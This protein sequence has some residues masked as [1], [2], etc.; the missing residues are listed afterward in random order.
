[1]LKVQ[2]PLTLDGWD[3]EFAAI[4]DTLEQIEIDDGIYEVSG[5]PIE[6]AIIEDIQIRICKDDKTLSDL[7]LMIDALR[8]VMYE[9]YT[10]ESD[11]ARI[12]SLEKIGTFPHDKDREAWVRIQVKEYKKRLVAVRRELKNIQGYKRMLAR[13]DE[14]MNNLGHNVRKSQKI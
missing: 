5:D 1:M 12:K 10:D 9:W 2:A 7:A 8:D 13:M 14:R 3:N 6:L 4:C 11:N